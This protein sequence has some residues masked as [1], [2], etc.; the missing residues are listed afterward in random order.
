MIRD[1]LVNRLRDYAPSNAL[2]QE[3]MLQETMQ[4]YI[5]ASLARGK[6][7]SNAAFHG[8]TCLRI[9]YGL[10]RFS[11]DL[12]FVLRAPDREF[13]WERFLDRIQ[14]D[15][16]AE[17]LRLEVGGRGPTDAT[18]K[19]VFLK[20]D[21]IGQILKLDLPYERRLRKKIR[22][23]L[24]VDT[25]PPSG[26]TFETKY[27][28]FPLTAA[29]TTMDLSS[30][31]GSKSHALLCR[32]YTKGRDW[33]DF[34]WYTARRVVPNL[35]LLSSALEQQ[36]PWAGRKLSVSREWYLDAM[37]HRIGTIEWSAARRDVERFVISREQPG[38]EAWSRD[39]FLEQLER[40]A[41][42]WPAKGGSRS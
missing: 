27:I 26:A 40:L 32:E 33:Y 42:A 38:L 2:E 29:I 15:S 8:G 22:V 5:L 13:E 39:L 17:G 20:T 19:K 24:E 30:G 31:F 9:L 14:S 11:E 6:F 23:K 41:E 34:L 37:K 21:S 3:N 10:I 7:F 18:V 4:H 1:V 12:D 35:A 36:G 16:V 28:I 25:N